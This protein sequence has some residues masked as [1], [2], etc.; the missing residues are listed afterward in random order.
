[1]TQ[2]WF[3]D[4]LVAAMSVSVC[5]FL[6]LILLEDVIL[7]RKTNAKARKKMHD[8]A[9]YYSHRK[10]LAIIVILL[11]ACT[12]EM[13]DGALFLQPLWDSILYFASASPTIKGKHPGTRI[14]PRNNRHNCT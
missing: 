8:G 1:M 11:C 6:S 14:N 13:H 3:R 2:G 7:G 9:Y 5:V 10:G 12:L 4:A